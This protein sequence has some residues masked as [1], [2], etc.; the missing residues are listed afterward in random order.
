MKEDKNNLGNIPTQEWEDPILR[1]LVIPM[2]I[3]E[4]QFC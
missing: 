2:L 4:L 3:I 1:V